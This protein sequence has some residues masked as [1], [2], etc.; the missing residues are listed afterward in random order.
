MLELIY[1]LSKVT[2]Y[3]MDIQKSAAFLYTN[4]NKTAEREIK[5]S[6]PFTI[7]SKTIRYLEIN[8]T[9]EIKVLYR[10]S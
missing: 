3:K 6:I 4:Y 2:G 10:E 8:L 7:T 9:R 1:E 5:E